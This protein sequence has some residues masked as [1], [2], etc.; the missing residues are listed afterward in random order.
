MDNLQTPVYITKKKK[1]KKNFFKNHYWGAT[2]EELFAYIFGM[3]K[4]LGGNNPLILTPSDSVAV[5]T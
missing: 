1:K 5:A 3:Y 2:V 4:K